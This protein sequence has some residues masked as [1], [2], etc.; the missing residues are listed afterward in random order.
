MSPLHLDS[1]FQIYLACWLLLCLIALTMYC[2]HPHD[3]SIS[4]QSYW[5]ALCVPWKL[6][7]FFIAMIALIVLAPYS[8]DPT[9]DTTDAIFMSV[10]TFISSPW[11]VG[12]LYQ[13]IRRR[14]FTR[15]SYLAICLWMFSASWSYDLYL[16]WRDGSYPI[17][18]SANIFASSIL[19]CCAG[20]LWNLDWKPEH[21]TTFA[22]TNPNW[23]D[24][25]SPATFR[26]IYW[27]GLPFIV[28]VAAALLSFLT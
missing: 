25:S 2:R 3:Y 21:G 7:T 19:Y 9:W 1:F 26:Q 11:S 12:T 4:R 6:S 17:T 18:W 5:R 16:L 20:L 13:T 10:L 15:Q 22:F 14:R 24:N 8:G 23:P 28:L 27:I